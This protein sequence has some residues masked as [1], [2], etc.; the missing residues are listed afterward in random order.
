MQAALLFEAAQIDERPQ[1]QYIE[2][3]AANAGWLLGAPG[4]PALAAISNDLRA[5]VKRQAVG[6]RWGEFREFAER[7][8]GQWQPY[9]NMARGIIPDDA[10]AAYSDIG[11]RSYYLADLTVIDLFGLTDATVARS[12]FNAPNEQR[13]MAH[14]RWPMPGYLE[15]RGVNFTPTPAANTPEDAMANATYAIQVGPDLWMPFDSDDPQ[16]VVKRFADTGRL[17]VNGEKI[18]DPLAVA[19]GLP[20]AIRSTYEVYYISGALIYIKEGCQL[21][22]VATNFMVHITPIDPADLPEERKIWGYNNYDFNIAGLGVPSSGIC[23][24]S[25]S[26]PHYPIAAIRTGQYNEQGRLWE[27]EIRLEQ[28]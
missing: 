24:L 22:D 5:S 2:L 10:I 1:E 25:R 23:A 11:I 9:A 21:T 20:V 3:D 17:L 26:L 19:S 16:W 13:V 18:S 4:M 28:Q 14:D 15:E 12:P 8:F 6:G 27:G 7:R